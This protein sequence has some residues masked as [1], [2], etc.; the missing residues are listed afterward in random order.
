MPV[1]QASPALAPLSVSAIN[2]T[3]VTPSLSKVNRYDT[4]AGALIITLPPLSGQNVGARMDIAKVDFSL[5]ALTVECPFGDFFVDGAVSITLT[6]GGEQRE[7]QIVLFEGA[8]AWALVGSFAAGMGSAVVDVIEDADGFYVSNDVGNASA[9][10]PMNYGAVGDGVA[11]DTAA[12]AAALDQLAEGGI[13]ILPPGKTFKWLGPLDIPMGVVVQGPGRVTGHPALLAGNAS[14]MIRMGLG[15]SSPFVY[16]QC[17]RDMIIDGNNIG[18]IGVYIGLSDRNALVSVDVN[19]FIH[20][21][22]VLDGAQNMTVIDCTAGNCA[23]GST[24]SGWPA[25]GAW[26]II[27]AAQAGRF[28][29]CTT[30]AANGLS[31]GNVNYRA[32]LITNILTDARFSDTVFGD[33]TPGR[34]IPPNGTGNG[35]FTWY[36]GISEYGKPDHRIEITHAATNMQFVWYDYAIAGLLSTDF[37][38][39]VKIGPAAGGPNNDTIYEFRN[40]AFILAAV[41]DM[42]VEASSGRVRITGNTG[43]TSADQYGMRDKIAISGSAS[44]YMDECCRQ[45]LWDGQRR[46]DANTTSQ[47]QVSGGTL[48]WDATT[49][50]LTYSGTAAATGIYCYYRGQAGETANGS[51]AKVGRLVRVRCYLT[52]IVGASG[53][54]IRR[55]GGLNTDIGALVAGYNELYYLMTDTGEFGV[56]IYQV[57]TET[58]SF[59]LAYIDIEH[60]AG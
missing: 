19:N 45:L 48:G 49:L 18:Q 2:T 32:W 46:F 38:G 7:Y 26:M 42:A 56:V 47:W 44:L 24:P 41:N 51:Y 23:T 31:T 40:C 36:G 50:R 59:K 33:D 11:D 25:C 30:A 37:L 20:A 6:E 54:R 8:K 12:L 9:A 57:A 27:N 35:P 34:M 3:A 4:S 53:F 13:L 28:Y 22:F 14:A 1:Q 60:I 16:R 58:A 10:S 29:N 17:L 21:G 39:A 52:D 55:F 15:P 43:V 5:N